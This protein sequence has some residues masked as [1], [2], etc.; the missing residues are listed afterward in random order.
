V[1]TD[2]ASNERTNERA[3]GLFDGLLH[4]YPDQCLIEHLA[5]LAKNLVAMASGSKAVGLL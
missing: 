2:A 4:N 3:C 1:G 5:R